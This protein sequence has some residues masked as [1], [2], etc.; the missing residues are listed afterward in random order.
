MLRPKHRTAFAADLSLAALIIIGWLIFP[1]CIARAAGVPETGAPPSPVELQLEVWVNGYTT[2]LIAQFVELPGGSLAV[3][4]E[5]LIDLEL[6]V[7]GNG[8]TTTSVRLDTIPGVTYRLDRTTQTLYL[9]VPKGMRKAKVY[10][11][12]RSGTAVDAGRA[13]YSSLLNYSLFAS[14]AQGVS[15]RTVTGAYGGFNGVNASLDGRFIAPFGTFSQTALVG[16][17]PNYYNALDPLSVSSV[18]ARRFDS[19][20]TYV[21]PGTFMTYKAGDTINGGLAWTRPVR[22][23]GF[24]VQRNF[25]ARPDIITQAL[26]SFSGSAAAP[27][28]V[29]VFVNG[30]KTYS[31]QVAAGPFQLANVPTIGGGEARVVVRDASGK[32]VETKLPFFNAPSLLRPGLYEA[33]A[34]VGVARYNFGITSNDYGESPIASVSLR[35]GITDWVTGEAHAEGGL[36]LANGGAGAVLNVAN[37]AVVAAAVTG[38]LQDGKAG[39]QLFGSIDTQ[40]GPVRV[41]AQ[42]QRAL[43][44]YTDLAI[45]SARLRPTTADEEARAAASGAAL[46]LRAYYRPAIARDQVTLSLPIAFDRSNVSATW[47]RTEPDRG[48]VSQIVSLSYARPFIAKSSLFATAYAN[49]DEIKKAGVYAGV[50]MP[51]GDASVSASVN[52]QSNGVTASVDAAKPLGSEPGEWGYRVRDSEGYQANRAAAISYRTE[53]VRL[54]A[55]VQQD[56]RSVRET[57]EASGSIVAM[58]GGVYMANRVEDGFA[59]VSAGAPGVRVLAENRFVGE[60][61]SDGM[62]LVPNL[63]SNQKNNISID[64]TNLSISAEVD[65][66]HQQV[67]PAYKSGVAVDF[68]VRREGS[69]AIVILKKPNGSYVDAGS[70]GRLASGGETF[71]V[72]YDG[73]AFIK[74]LQAQNT[75]IV[76]I[77]KSECRAS[78]GFKPKADTQVVIGPVVCE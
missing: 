54:E 70:N 44:D 32:E 7:P 75:I 46:D 69:S 48:A 49:V 15:A 68:K 20:F 33:S 40:V 55:T 28:S 25:T 11:A 1:L 27:S 61:D 14:A 13:D 9:T 65:N 53:K 30:V 64:P 10:D 8:A 71:L 17:I 6:V 67:V 58:K 78:F 50:S 47:I 22:M 41:H 19:T 51:L 52:S 42:T 73:Q 38:S 74:G 26:P 2:N 37:R 57:A 18:D 31:Q 45:A 23:G 12:T 60:T 77:D 24:Q 16:T 34:E 35:S 43:G 3:S 66:P 59:V 56:D 63:R 39:V 62:L 36:G 72:G 4:R 21:D 76:V 5:A 29:D